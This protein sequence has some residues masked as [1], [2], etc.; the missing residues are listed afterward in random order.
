MNR[1]QDFGKL[2]REQ[3]L[4]FED[5]ASKKNHYLK[6]KDHTDKEEVYYLISRKVPIKSQESIAFDSEDAQH[7]AKNF[8]RNFTEI[9]DYTAK[10]PTENVEEYIDFFV[11]DPTRYPPVPGIHALIRKAGDLAFRAQQKPSFKVVEPEWSA[12]KQRASMTF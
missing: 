7:K 11:S 9:K 1:E 4:A 8:I 5:I 3:W 12:P 10:H 2:L 6:N